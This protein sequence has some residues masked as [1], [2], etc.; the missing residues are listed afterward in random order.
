MGLKKKI[1]IVSR[2]SPLS[3]LQVKEMVGRFPVFAY[4]LQTLS[5]FGD[6]NKQISL[7]E[8][9]ASDFFTR[10]LDLAL[11]SHQAD[12]SIH[13]AKDLPYPLPAELELFCLTEAAD[14]SDSLVSR[15]GVRL[16][17]L[18]TGSRIGTSSKTRKEEL[19]KLRPDLQ[20][21]SIRGTIGERIAQIDNG[22]IDGLIV[23][24]CA[25][26]RLGLSDRITEILPFKTHPL[27]GH[28]ALIGRKEDSRLKDFF[29]QSDIRKEYGTVT[30]VGFGPGNADLLTIGGDMA[31]SEADVIF[32]DDLLDKNF[33]EKYWGEKIYVG[34]RKG[35]HNFQQD[36]INELMYQSAI[37]GK[38]VV[39]LKGGD[40][41]IFAHGREEIDFLKSRFVEVSVIPGVTSA[42]ALSAFTHIPLTHRNM[43]SSVAFV[44]GHSAE[45]VALVKADTLVI[46]MGGAN[47]DGIAEKLV[48][49]GRNAETPVALVHNASLP[50]QQIFY[51]TLKELQFTVFKFPTPILIVVG[52]VVSFEKR[53]APKANVLVT[54][55][56]VNSPANA[57]KVTHTPLIKIAKNKELTA[58]SQF[59]KEL[60][61][62][63][64]IV[65][66]SRYGVRYFFEILDD[67][68]IDIRTISNARIASVGSTTSKELRKYRFYPD[69]E[70]STESA[71]GLIHYFKQNNIIDKQ[72]LLPRSN[73]GLKPLSD[74][75]AQLG[76]QV[77]DVP[78]Y[79]NTTNGDAEKVDTTLFRKI[80]F[81]SPS[82]VEAFVELYRQLPDNAQLIA[83][84]PTTKRR[85]KEM[86]N[87]KI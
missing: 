56:T 45:N 17:E 34:K 47:V 63:D 69:I 27:Q 4:E 62:Y 10:E 30:L 61:H 68:K 60:N 86:I 78:V 18:P 65:F 6:K 28:L 57:E 19:Q 77:T 13:S 15:N 36:E 31:L 7:M 22:S 33:L 79:I 20:V 51:S 58:M 29:S 1:K 2:N 35:K 37:A 74:Q 14:K 9:T 49:S 25:L 40:P 32:H 21:V 39:R 87:E 16:F 12:I 75:L 82:C 80:I 46:Y 38:K 73:K 72:I 70:S 41:M 8:N 44:T 55:T 81:S 42:L 23:A 71:E 24:T 43:A 53:Y 64:W 3:L 59:K 85:I 11:V 83:K 5:S 76:N 67:L 54:G 66:T 48:E 84:G 50:D 26:N 52:E